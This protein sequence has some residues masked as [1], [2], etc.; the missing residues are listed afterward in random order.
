MDT[1]NYYPVF[2]ADQ[3]LTAKHLNDLVAYL[4]QQE[5]LTR[6][7][8][9]GVGVLCGMHV[10]NVK[11]S[12]IN[13]GIKVPCGCGVTSEGYLIT[14]GAKTFTKYTSYKDP[15]SYVHFS[16]SNGNQNIN[17]WELLTADDSRP[18]SIIS[19]LEENTADFDLDDMAVIAYLEAVL[20]DLKTCTEENCDE[21]GKKMEFNLRFLLISKADLV[22]IINKCKKYSLDPVNEK[23]LQDYIYG[24]YF[25]P[26]MPMKRFGIGKNFVHYKDISDEY[27]SLITS[28]AGNLFNTLAESYTNYK[29]LLA[30]KYNNV[31]PF[32]AIKNAFLATYNQ[33]LTHQEYAIQYYY[34]FL[35]DL[36]QAY[37][38]FRIAAF[39][40]ISECC[41]DFDCFPLH[42]MLGEAINKKQCVPTIYRHHFVRP[43]ESNGQGSRLEEIFMLFDRLVLLT[44]SFSVPEFSETPIKITPSNEDL[45]PLSLKSIPYYFDDGSPYAINKFWNYDLKRKCRPHHIYSYNSNK[46]VSET[47]PAYVK[48]ALEFNID[49]YPFLR[50]EG[51]I[52]KNYVTVLK[53]IQEFKKKYRLPFDVI[54]VKL[55]TIYKNIPIK[56][57]CN[58]YDIL[59]MYAFLRY[60]IMCSL[61][62]AGNYVGGMKYAITEGQRNM[63]VDHE[64]EVHEMEGSLRSM[65]K[66][67]TIGKLYEKY[68]KDPNKIDIA[69]YTYDF[70]TRKKII[71]KDT[72]SKEF[73][74][75]Y[76]YP[77]QT[78]DAIN[79]FAETIPLNLNQFNMMDFENKFNS[80]AMLGESFKGQIESM[81]E[82]PELHMQAFT[83]LD[84]SYIGCYL[85]KMKSFLK[86]FS[87]R[88]TNMQKMQL[89]SAYSKKHP[90]IEHKAGVEKGGTFILVY[91][92]PEE[93]EID[94]D[95]I[96]K[97]I[98]DGVDNADISDDDKGRITNC[99]DNVYGYGYAGYANYGASRIGRFED[100]EKNIYSFD[101]PS[102]VGSGNI[103]GQEV[104]GGFNLNDFLFSTE[105]LKKMIVVADFCL[106]YICCSDCPPIVCSIEE[107]PKEPEPRDVG[108]TISPNELCERA[109]PADIILIPP[110]GGTLTVTG[111][112]QNV[113]NNNKFIP[114]NVGLGSST[115]KTVTLK[116]AFN[117]VE[118]TANVTVYSMPHV[119]I[120]FNIVR[121]SSDAS[122]VLF[123][124]ELSNTITDYTTYKWRFSRQDQSHRWAL[125]QADLN[126]PN[127]FMSQL[128]QSTLPKP[129]VFVVL[130]ASRG[131]MMGIAVTLD[132][133]NGPD[134]L[135]KG[136]GT[137][138]VTVINQ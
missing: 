36:I 66:D 59:Q 94:R 42:L 60:E 6:N 74:V 138:D 101:E 108:I 124:V 80:L 77:M 96:I 47:A 48:K 78:L 137:A 71:T 18:D 111:A 115:K 130:K 10:L 12:T 86:Y 105:D 39:D 118:K 99:I 73:A 24:K 93:K 16:D 106:P 35:K 90:G 31:N 28:S 63:F 100:M 122:T 9:I 81:A 40:Y 29:I 26:E 22:K 58:F 23:E 5:R 91:M 70:L 114:S 54:G 15:A 131:D 120:K 14:T 7:W 87:Q 68:H 134:G 53:T 21:K 69:A 97:G 61:K 136:T 129:T 103:A 43:P 37:N 76:S 121:V 95:I 51:H 64:T 44:K 4:E 107:R 52:G 98:R 34:D 55:G 3:V 50:I 57:D 109:D 126:D 82:N 113:I 30:H 88:V 32:I 46:Y 116:Y 67:E 72:P 20:V 117:N 2:E 38:D 27:K 41:P 75:K 84:Y 45:T 104:L 102:W 17:L 128:L 11:N 119:D 85:E 13:F 92:D 1:I 110:T 79:K 49:D 112:P 132:V 127:I 125:S 89:F 62:K 56:G 8:L 33:M 133:I 25:L 135:C 65:F 83:V 123:A 19:D